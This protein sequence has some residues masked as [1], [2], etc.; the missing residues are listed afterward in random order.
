MTM[1]LFSPEYE[2]RR[3]RL[4]GIIRA[5]DFI[6]EPVERKGGK[7]SKGNN[8]V[9]ECAARLPHNYRITPPSMLGARGAPIG[10]GN[11]TVVRPK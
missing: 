10:V 11:S 6:M 8:C 9:T 1:P 4:S 7:P 5:G 2:G 3:N